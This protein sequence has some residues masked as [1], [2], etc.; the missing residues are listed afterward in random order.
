M[1]SSD[2]AVTNRELL[3]TEIDVL[4]IN[5]CNGTFSYEGAMVPG[6]ICAS[7]VTKNGNY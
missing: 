2:I 4:D 7:R 3:K 1:I 6:M 5:F